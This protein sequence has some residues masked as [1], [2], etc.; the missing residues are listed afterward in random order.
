MTNLTT[1][2]ITGAFFALLGLFLYFVF[3]PSSVEQIE[4]VWLAPDTFPNFLSILLTGFG[5]A[6]IIFPSEQ[7]PPNTAEVAKVGLY[8]VILTIGYYAIAQI[9]YVYI[10]P[11]I[12]LAIMLIL[13]ERRLLWLATGVVLMPAIIWF[14]I[15]I[16]LDRSL[17]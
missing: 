5:A 14:A 15:V 8:V 10:A 7:R 16:L 3:I 6:L 9:G 12:A 4:S 13:G 1:D 2:R 11:L 17:P